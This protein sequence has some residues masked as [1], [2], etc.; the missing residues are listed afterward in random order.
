MEGKWR[1]KKARLDAGFR[2]TRQGSRKQ[3]CAAIKT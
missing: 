1:K 2:F 3:G